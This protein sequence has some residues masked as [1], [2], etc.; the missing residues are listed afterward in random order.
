MDPDIVRP[1]LERAYRIILAMYLV[2]LSYQPSQSAL[3]HI[4]SYVVYL[5]LVIWHC[6]KLSHDPQTILTGYSVIHHLFSQRKD[7]IQVLF[8]EKQ[9]S[10]ELV[11]C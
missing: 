11:V 8:G 6:R 3:S 10:A 4:N 1:N 5:L 9:L 2:S 7:I